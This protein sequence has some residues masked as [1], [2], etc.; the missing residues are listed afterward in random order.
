MAMSDTFPSKPSDFATF[1]YHKNPLYE[2][3]WIRF[4]QQVAR[5]RPKRNT[6]MM[7]IFPFW[8]VII[9]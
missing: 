7:S 8:T 5:I 2:L 1:F 6:N 9:F 3:H 4:C